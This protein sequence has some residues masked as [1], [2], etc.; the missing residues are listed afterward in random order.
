MDYSPSRVWGDRLLSGDWDGETSVLLPTAWSAGKKQWH[1]SRDMP[2][3]MKELP[4]MAG[5]RDKM[6]WFPGK[7]LG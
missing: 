3:D 7:A 6:E 4:V 5:Q 2:P 1:P